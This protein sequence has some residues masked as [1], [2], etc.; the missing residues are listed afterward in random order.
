MCV[1]WG[2]YMDV[3]VFLYNGGKTT[4]GETRILKCGFLVEMK[5]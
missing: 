5:I 1:S 2:E 3:F 4:S